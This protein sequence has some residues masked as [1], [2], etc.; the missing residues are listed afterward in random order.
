MA[1]KS[2]NSILFYGTQ[3]AYEAIGTK[4]ANKLYFTDAGKLYKG[5]IDITEG[6]RVVASKPSAPVAG[7]TYVIGS[8]EN[9]TVEV[10]NGTEWVVIC[11]KVVTAV[12]AT[13]TDAEIAT[14]KA[15]YT[16]VSGVDSKVGDLSALTT[17]AKDTT[18]AAI[19]EV[20][21][22]ANDNATAIGSVDEAGTGTGIKKDIYDIKAELDGLGTASTK[23]FATTDIETEGEVADALPTVSQV[24]TYVKKKVSDLVGAM[25]FCGTVTPTGEQS[26]AD[27]M[28]A[29][30]TAKSQTPKQGDVFVIS[31]NTKEYIVSEV[32][33]AGVASYVEIGS[34]GLYVLKTQT[35]A[36]L[37]LSGNITKEAL[38]SA[39]NVEDGAQVNDLEG[40]QVNG[41]D[42]TIDANK[43]VNVTVATGS[44]NGT[45]AVNGTDVAVK[46]L[47]SAAF[48][49]SDAYD[50]AGTADTLVGKLASL[51]TDAKG[52]VVAAINEV[53]AHADAAQA[54]ADQNTLDIAALATA[55]TAWGTF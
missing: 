17:T 55:T 6:T 32:S 30:Y 33:E 46:G 23:D 31:T 44:A 52:T 25:H 19:N 27:A 35:I 11:N 50:A 21:G 2:Y 43:K 29:W 16:A 54:T 48:T 15:V 49:D 9:K 45:I 5:S 24:E 14:A 12:S 34:E 41:A 51:T 42:L 20:S 4:D 26:D 3:A 37:A 18:V 28:N 1:A 38:L 10:W 53:D 8:G 22:I 36:G 47:G 13:S 40:V 39:L 7:I